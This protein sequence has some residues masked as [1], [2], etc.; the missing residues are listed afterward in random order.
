[1]KSLDSLLFSLMTI[2]QL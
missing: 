1:M 2:P